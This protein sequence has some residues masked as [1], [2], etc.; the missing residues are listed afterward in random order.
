MERRRPGGIGFALRFHH[1]KQETPKKSQKMRT[2]LID[3]N[4]CVLFQNIFLKK[5]N[6]VDST[7]FS[8][9]VALAHDLQ[10]TGLFCPC[11]FYR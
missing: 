2:C 1:N 5:E 10:A 11:P 9:V 7:N 6:W 3:R 4:L 8:R